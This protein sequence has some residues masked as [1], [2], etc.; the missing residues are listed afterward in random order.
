[1]TDCCTGQPAARRWCSWWAWQLHVSDGM[2]H[3]T[4]YQQKELLWSY[5]VMRF[6]NFAHHI[7][8]ACISFRCCEMPSLGTLTSKV[9]P[10]C[11]VEISCRK[12]PLIFMWHSPPI[13]RANEKAAL[14]LGL[15]CYMVKVGLV[16]FLV[17]VDSCLCIYIDITLHCGA[18]LR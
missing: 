6:G 3:V 14:A 12:W 9:A 2:F 15:T 11:C 13:P 7:A 1:M 17:N 8:C 4:S 16:T 5:H 10:R 18:S